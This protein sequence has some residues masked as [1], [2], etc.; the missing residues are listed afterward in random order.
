MPRIPCFSFSERSTSKIIS[1]CGGSFTFGTI[2]PY[3][4]VPQ[5][6]ATIC[7]L[8]CPLSHTQ[9]GALV[10]E[11]GEL[12]KYNDLGELAVGEE[13]GVIVQKIL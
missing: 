11:L 9:E 6:L 7:C 12:C 3:S 10:F 1:Q 5:S 2:I 8:T 4:T 13:G